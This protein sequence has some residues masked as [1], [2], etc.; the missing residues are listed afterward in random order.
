[1]MKNL[2]HLYVKTLSAEHRKFSR[3]IRKFT[4]KQFFLT[5]IPFDLKYGKLHREEIFRI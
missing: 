5:R 4:Y 2:R 1:M 3:E